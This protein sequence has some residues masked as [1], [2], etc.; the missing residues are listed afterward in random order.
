PSSGATLS[1][2][3]SAQKP[4]VSPAAPAQSSSSKRSEPEVD[5][6]M[7]KLIMDEMKEVIKKH[8]QAENHIADVENKLSNRISAVSDEIEGIKSKLKGQE[9]QLEQIVRNLDKFISLYE[10]VINQYNPFIEHV[11]PSQGNGSAQVASAIAA[12][13]HITPAAPTAPAPA[14]AV[15][16]VAAPTTPAVA[17]AAITDKAGTPITDL[18]VLLDELRAMSPEQYTATRPLLSG[19]VQ[20]FVKD[21][22]LATQFGAA[23]LKQQDAIKLL[24]KKSLKMNFA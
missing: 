20:A 11:N 14:P 13:P 6:S 23:D 8:Q 2:S 22:A 9:A 10:I 19:W 17:Q 21:Q 24:L 4:A 15:A 1:S 5:D 18:S 7:V 12:M 16:Q 3:S